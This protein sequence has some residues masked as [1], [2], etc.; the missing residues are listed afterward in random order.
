MLS[1][2]ISIWFLHVNTL[3]SPGATVILV[4]QLAARDRKIR[5]WLFP[6]Q[7]LTAHSKNIT[8]IKTHEIKTHEK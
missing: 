6:K 4:L 2:F 7:H 3:F 8:F 1:T 5:Y